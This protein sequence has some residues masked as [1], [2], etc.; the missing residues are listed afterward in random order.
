MYSEWRSGE[1]MSVSGAN[2]GQR[3]CLRRGKGEGYETKYANE[4][5]TIRGGSAVAVG[6]GGEYGWV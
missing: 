6:E 3:V 5:R 1:M 2:S 4:V